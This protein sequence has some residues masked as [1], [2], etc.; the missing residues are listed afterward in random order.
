MPSSSTRARG[1]KEFTSSWI[2]LA[3]DKIERQ[4]RRYKEKLNHHHG[5]ERVHHRQEMLNNLKVRYDV[6]EI[7]PPED[8]V[9][10]EVHPKV[11]RT[12]EFFAKPMSLDEA[13]MQMDL[14]NN[15]IMVFTNTV[16]QEMNIVYRRKDGHYGLIEATAGRPA[17]NSVQPKK[18]G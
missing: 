12:N 14:M 1:S 7:R 13:V 5:R 6:V 10:P 8:Q 2:E 11:I 9:A 4:L 15:D 3:M 16:S 17:A 18:A